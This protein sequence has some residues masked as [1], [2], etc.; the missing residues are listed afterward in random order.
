MAADG[1]GSARK[2]R[3]FLGSGSK[4]EELRQRIEAVRVECRL[5][6]CG[7]TIEF[8]IKEWRRYTMR[9]VTDFIEYSL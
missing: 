8:V 7:D 2:V 4:G 6:T 9:H 1:G 3:V 5:P